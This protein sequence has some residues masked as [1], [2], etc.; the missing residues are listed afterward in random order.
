MWV[1]FLG[2]PLGCWNASFFLKIGA[3]F[4]EALMVDD[5][6][7]KRKRL[8]KGRVLALIPYGLQCPEKVEVVED[9]NAFV[10][11]VEGIKDKGKKV[12]Q[13]K[14]KFRPSFHR[15]C[16][17]GPGKKNKGLRHAINLTKITV[18]MAP[19]LSENGV[20]GD[21]EREEDEEEEPRLKYQRMGGSIP[22]LISNDAASCIAVAERMIALGT[23]TGTV[24][25]LDFL[26]NQ[27]FAAHTVAV[28]D[29]SFHLEGIASFGDSLV[30]LDYIP[31]EE[32][33]ENEFSS[34]NSITAG[35]FILQSN[36][37][38]HFSIVFYLALEIDVLGVP[39]LVP[40][41]IYME[42]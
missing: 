13:R 20:E 5:V 19:I 30:V 39:L 28:N 3:V 38:F 2:V 26:G 23:H 31:G 24:H 4:G 29:L 42:L 6:T 10:V 35:I 34:T 21:D 22:S 15:V 7:A 36:L 14:P 25:I 1:E 11:L 37:N 41:F 16:Q 27:E 32:D 8:D 17:V 18:Q 12:L 33:R 9:R 40:F